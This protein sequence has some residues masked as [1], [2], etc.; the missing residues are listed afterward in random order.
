MPKLVFADIT[1]G[2]FDRLSSLTVVLYSCRR[3]HDKPD[4]TNTLLAVNMYSNF[5]MQYGLDDEY[6]CGK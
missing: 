2:T 4:I 3:T 6:D 1:N 5:E